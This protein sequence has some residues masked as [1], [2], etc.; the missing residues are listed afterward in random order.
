M[1]WVAERMQRLQRETR[2]RRISAWMP[3]AE[4]E[5]GAP[6]QVLLRSPALTLVLDSRRGGRLL[7]LS[8]K[9]SG[10]VL[11]NSGWIDHRF[12]PRARLRDFA[13][14]RFHEL[15]ALPAGSCS[16][17][18]EEG[19]GFIRSILDRRTPL[20]Q[21]AKSV[22]L[23]TRGRRVLFAHRLTNLS[24]RRMDFLFGTG[25]TLNL[26]DAHVNRVGE[27]PGVRQFAVLDPAARLEVRWRFSR[28]ARI[29][30]FP[31]ESGS[32]ARRVYR[33]VKLTGLWPVKLPPGKSWQLQWQLEIG[34]PSG[35]H[36][37]KK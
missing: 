20:L 7:E 13:E 34:E 21:V 23:P 35:W 15:P 22:T 31:L 32:G 25:L 26:K 17:R 28:P 19:K 29:W 2:K 10:R 27:A 9:K 6:G 12:G 14:G 24:G 37:G 18:V 36:P 11:L 5:G 3:P 16:A 8:D 33:G 1:S 4:A 30:Y